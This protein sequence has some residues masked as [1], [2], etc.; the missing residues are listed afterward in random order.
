MI[1]Q[2][3]KWATEL[4]E[5]GYHYPDIIAVLLGSCSGYAVGVLA[6]YYFVPV[7]LPARTQQ[8]LSILA[9]Q[10]SGTLLSAMIWAHTTPLE[11]RLAISFCA[12][13]VGCFFYPAIARIVTK[14]V[15]AVGSVWA[16][17]D[18]EPPAQ[19]TKP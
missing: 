4:V 15:P 13:T 10:V 8:A 12:A 7:T 1:D 19:A 2:I 9:T 17:R 14:F 11:L 5:F 16:K 6:E 18:D 3:V